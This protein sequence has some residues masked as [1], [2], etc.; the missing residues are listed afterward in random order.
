MCVSVLTVTYKKHFRTSSGCPN[1][2]SKNMPVWQKVSKLNLILK[3]YHVWQDSRFIGCPW[4]NNILPIIVYPLHDSVCSFDVISIVVTAPAYVNLSCI[5]C[6]LPLHLFFPPQLFLPWNSLKLPWRLTGA[7]FWWCCYGRLWM[8]SM[9][10]QVSSILLLPTTV[11]FSVCSL[12]SSCTTY[13]VK[14]TII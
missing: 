10:V 9:Q 5:L 12:P 3:A 4:V 13:D 8:V 1:K 2:V 14:M 11:H 6:A 7:L